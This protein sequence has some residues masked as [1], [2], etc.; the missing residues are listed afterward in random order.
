MWEIIQ[1]EHIKTIQVGDVLQKQGRLLYRVTAILPKIKPDR[2]MGAFLNP[3]LED[4]KNMYDPS[5]E[6]L[7]WETALNGEWKINISEKKKQE[8]NQ[9]PFI[10]GL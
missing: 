8:E 3:N 10:S 9:P 6:A 5:N 2:F 4:M 1:P 7:H